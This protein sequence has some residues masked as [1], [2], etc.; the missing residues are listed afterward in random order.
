M[1]G[2]PLIEPDEVTLTDGILLG[3]GFGWALLAVLSVRFSDQPQWWAA[4]PA[5]FFGLIRGL[6]LIWPSR[7]VLDV[8]SWVWPPAILGLVVLMIIGARRRLRSRTRERLV[9]PLLATLTLAAVQPSLRRPVSGRSG[10]RTA[11]SPMPPTSRSFWSLP[12]L[13]P[14]RRPFAM[15]SRR[16]GPQAP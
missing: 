2:A 9:Y 5:V 15:L 1:V 12:T 16:F 10:R 6:M 11:S 8:L 13:R 4:E 7:L 14:L 3:I